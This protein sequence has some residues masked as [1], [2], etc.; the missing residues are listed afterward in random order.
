MAVDHRDVVPADIAARL[1]AEKIAIEQAMHE[2][3]HGVVLRHQQAGQPLVVWQDGKVVLIP[4]DSIQ[5][6]E[7]AR[8]H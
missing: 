1:D 6:D 5:P 2:V 3:V 7:A 4:A 8:L